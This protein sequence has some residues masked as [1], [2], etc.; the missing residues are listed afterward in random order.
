MYVL[1]MQPLKPR[2]TPRS[3]CKQTHETDKKT[4]SFPQTFYSCKLT[5]QTELFNEC[6]NLVSVL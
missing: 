6:D 1:V 2:P 4:I 3:K 5:K